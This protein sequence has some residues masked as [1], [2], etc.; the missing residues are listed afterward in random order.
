MGTVT[1]DWQVRWGSNMGANNVSR[2]GGWVVACEHRR[3]SGQA[4]TKNM[5]VLEG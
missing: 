5:S 1:P 4:T 2:I 3:I